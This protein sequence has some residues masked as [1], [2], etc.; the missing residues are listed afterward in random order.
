MPETWSSSPFL[1]LLPLLLS[2]E[3]LPVCLALELDAFLFLIWASRNISRVF[4]FFFFWL[5]LS[6]SLSYPLQR[7]LSYVYFILLG[8]LF[9]N[10]SY[11]YEA[12]FYNGQKERDRHCLPA[13]E[14]LA[15]LNNIQNKKKKKLINSRMLAIELEGEY[16]YNE[17]INYKYRPCVLF[18]AISIWIELIEIAMR[19]KINTLLDK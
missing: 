15:L 10:I 18:I 6:L 1:S 7:E 4:G 11:N 16:V 19:I 12:G 5:F 9:S 3:M 17:P 8:A 14:R 13:T 2:W